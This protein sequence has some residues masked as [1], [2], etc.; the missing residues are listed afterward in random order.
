[1]VRQG[2]LERSVFVEGIYYEMHL[3][4]AGEDKNGRILEEFLSANR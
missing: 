1:L 2:V 4:K 3:Y